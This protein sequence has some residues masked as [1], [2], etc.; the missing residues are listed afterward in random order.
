MFNTFGLSF[1]IYRDTSLVKHLFLQQVN[2]VYEDVKYISCEVNI[3]NSSDSAGE[4]CVL[5]SP[6][7]VLASE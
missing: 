2:W 7:G 5:Q 6:P 1:Y 4:N 3:L